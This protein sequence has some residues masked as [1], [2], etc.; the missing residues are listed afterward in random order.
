MRIV[1]LEAENVKKLTA[2]DITPTDDM[3]LITGPNGAGKSSI[4]DCIVMALCGGREIPAVPIKKGADKGKIVIELE[5]Y[6]IIRSFTKEGSYLRIE[7]LNG[8]KVSSPQKFLDTIVGNISFDPLDFLNNEKKKQKDILL[9]LL[10]VNVDELEKEEKDLREQ[11][12]IAGRDVKRTEAEFKSAEHYPDIKQT[13]ELSVA[14]L[15]EKMESIL[16][17]NT[18]WDTKHAQNESLK[19]SA[20]SHENRISEINLEIERLQTEKEL[21]QREIEA[22][23]VQYKTTKT[24]LQE[25]P[26]QDAT[27]I[28]EEMGKVSDINCKIVANRKREEAKTAW[29]GFVET[30]DALTKSIE[31]V[32]TRRKNLLAG[33]KMPV[34]GLSFDDGGLLYNGIP[35]DQASDGE[36]LM[37]SLGI[38]MALNPTLR[39]LRIKDGSLLDEKNRGIIR[40]MI[41]EQDYQLWYETVGIDSKVGLLIEE[42]EIVAMDGQ[43]VQKKASK[44]PATQKETPAPEPVKE[45]PVTLPQPTGDED[46]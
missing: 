10:G 43:P 41:K 27:S 45:E 6:R 2:V 4:L 36:K 25:S 11:R 22:W 33:A 9:Q 15:S 32:E 46:W 42:G 17:N 24:E 28:S 38:S 5:E 26:K 34:E 44:K 13:E 21:K 3:I 8:S 37:V 14:D 31:D 40:S 39:V 29:N 23:K 20:K 12:T 7:N 19:V 18:A 35:L 30:Y 16:K 1:R